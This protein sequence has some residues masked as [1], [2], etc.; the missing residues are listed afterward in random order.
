MAKQDFLCEIGCAELPTKSVKL[1]SHFLGATLE[2]ELLRAGLTFGKIKLFATPRRVAAI[3]NDL[4]TEQ[5]PQ[6][7]ERQGPSYDKAYDKDGIPTLACI[8]FAKSCGVSVDELLFIESDKGKRVYCKVTQPGIATKEI[9]PSLVNNALR[10]FPLSKAMRW[11]NYDFEFVR[12][13]QWVVM[14][15]GNEVISATILGKPAGRETQG[16]R[17]HAARAIRITE[18]KDYSTILYS[19]AHVI[20]DYTER[21]TVIEKAIND[22]IAS[23]S[24]AIIN[25]DLLDEV[26]SLVEWPVALCGSFN[27]EFLKVPKEVLITSMQTHQKYFPVEKN[28]ELQPRFI[29]ISNIES[30]DP[31]Q[32]IHGNERVLNARLSD[33]AFFYQNDLKHSLESR[34]ERL[35]H[36]VFEKQL[37]TLA[38]RSERIAL[39]AKN[40]AEKLDANAQY[41]E[42]AGRLSK[43][44]LV[45][46]MVTEF[47]DLQG[48]MGYYYAKN[49]N[50][51]EEIA[52]AIKEHY[53]PRFSGDELP[54]TLVGCAVSIAT[55]LDTLIGILGIN[56]IPTGD[57]DPYALRRT[58]QGILRILIEKELP[59][60]LM[61]LLQQTQ[62]AY[63][64]TL[65]N[66]EIITQ[67]FS[68]MMDRLKYWYL[69]Q[70]VPVEVFEAVLTCQPTSPRDFDQRIK[71]VQKFQK[72]PEA[73]ALAAANKRVSNI[74]KKTNGTTI[75]NKTNEKLFEMDEERILSKQL[76]THQKSLDKLYQKADY[77]QA[78]T[79]LAELKEPI[80]NFFEKVMVMT[81]DEKVRNNR[82]ALLSLLRQLFSR[83]ADISLLP[84]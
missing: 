14:L 29:L 49:D 74:L 19:E 40:I 1:L 8:G 52:I 12:P 27:P 64:I 46:E 23:N 78:L 15:F 66:K 51:P 43:C 48:T 10:Q 55:R 79:E 39:L 59:L 73:G 69:D 34:F 82:L 67:A 11:G 2:K 17:F 70:G 16:H 57:K 20:A 80:D 5:S 65:P 32:V 71:A 75:P 38:K 76:Q 58:A 28:G 22:S 77:T 33:A 68:F 81:E 30:R 9:L 83:V 31:K 18:P 62:K 45:S 56:K 50:E 26:T 53:Y 7:I 60:D 41:A 21:K 35:Q 44:D 36:I 3:V 72:L 4:I 37:G 63:D 13:V 42:H 24:N 61:D 6:E 84:S 25:P 54:S 47:P